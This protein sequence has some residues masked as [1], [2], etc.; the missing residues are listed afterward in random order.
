MGIMQLG[1]LGLDVKDPAPWRAILV[2]VLGMQLRE[3]SDATYL[4]V[5]ERH[6]RLVLHAGARNGTAYVGWEVADAAAM[7]ALAGH[8][9]AAGVEVERGS[10]ADCDRRYVEGLVSFTDLNGIRM[11]IFHDAA[12]DDTSFSP[13]RE[14]GGF[15]TNELGLGHIVCASREPQASVDFYCDNL[16]FRLTD[17]IEMGPMWLAFLRCNPRHHSLG[18]GS[19]RPGGTKAGN[20]SHL[21]VE[22]RT[23]DDVGLAWDL[24]REKEIPLWMSLGKHSNDHMVSF[25][26]ITPSGLAIEY[27]YGGRRIDDATWQVDHLDTTSIWGHQKMNPKPPGD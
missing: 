7:D 2:D 22:S 5:D 26:L 18:F 23:L 27:G 25:Y 17:T 6:H 20:L 16:G 3:S 11:E 12:T 14:T 21:M 13:L 15:V 24:C 1:Y 9:E 8:L 19:E 4:R 10:D